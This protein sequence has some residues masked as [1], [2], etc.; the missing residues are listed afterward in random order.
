MRIKHPRL[1]LTIL[2]PAGM[3]RSLLLGFSACT[4]FG[5]EPPQRP[6]PTQPNV[7]Y[8]E[9]ANQ[10]IDLYIPSSGSGPFPVFIWFGGIWKPSRSVP[11]PQRF[12][13]AGIA[14]V[15]AGTR[16]LTD[17]MNDQ[18]KEPVSYLMNDATRVVQ[19]VRA[20]ATEWHLDGTRLALGGSSQGALPALYVGCSPD[21]ADATSPD[22]VGRTSTKVLLV[23]A[24]RCQPT[25]DPQLMQSWVPGVEWGAPALGLPFKESL[26]RRN[27]LLPIINRWSPDKLLGPH[28]APIYFENNWGLTQPEKVTVA[29]Y[30]VHS[31]RWA[32]GFQKLA[33]AAGVTCLVKY[34][35]HPTEGYQD[36]WDYVTQRLTAH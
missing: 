3:L 16:T 23:A 2:H 36:I 4:L 19:F 9:H 25:I 29:D 14:L 34:P 1:Q 20:H 8:G 11:D 35:N 33:L 18:Q 28:S 24:H 30:N 6:A 5:A 32:L 31:P 27:E 10:Q 26:S 21:H 13:R 12:L 15:A 7:S 22:P 17:G